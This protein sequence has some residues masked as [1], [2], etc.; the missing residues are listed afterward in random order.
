MHIMSTVHG[1][2][3]GNTGWTQGTILLSEITKLQKDKHSWFPLWKNLNNQVNEG[4]EDGMDCE[5]EV[6]EAGS[7]LINH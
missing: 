6:R 2:T 1:P 4:S 3:R 5:A 7:S